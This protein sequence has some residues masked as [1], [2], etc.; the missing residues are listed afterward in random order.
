[1]RHANY[2]GMVHQVELQG[3]LFVE[4]IERRRGNAA[5]VQAVQQRR[6]IDRRGR[7]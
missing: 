6:F 5:A 2:P 3:R 7:S 1:M 4:Y